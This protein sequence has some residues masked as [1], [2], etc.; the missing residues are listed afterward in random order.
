M[1]GAEGEGDR[2]KRTP[3][4]AGMGAGLGVDLSS[5]Q[6]SPRLSD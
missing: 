3:P 4:P 2:L 1:R 6:E 5:N